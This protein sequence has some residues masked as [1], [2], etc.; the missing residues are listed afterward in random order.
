MEYQPH[1][2][3]VRATIGEGRGWIFVSLTLVGAKP[4]EADTWYAV[5]IDRDADGRGDWLVAYAGSEA[6]PLSSDWSADGVAVYA[7]SNEDVGGPRPLQPDPPTS[8]G[9]GFETLVLRGG[10]TSSLV[11]VRLSPAGTASL[12]FAMQESVF[13]P[14]RGFLWGVWVDGQGRGPALF[15]YHDH[16]RFSEAGSPSTSSLYYPLKELASVDSTC[17]WAF[18]IPAHAG[19]PGLC[20]FLPP[21]PVPTGTVT[22]TP[23]PSATPP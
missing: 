17:R 4:A 18:G 1:L 3:I 23:L 15:D 21:T 22:S 9:D 11:W 2:D 16:F 12:D 8:A 14:G 19:L 20:G 13:G 5:E 6:S 10:P 7:D